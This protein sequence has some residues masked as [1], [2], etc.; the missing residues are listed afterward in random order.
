MEGRGDEG[1]RPTQ[2]GQR[3]MKGRHSRDRGRGG[4]RDPN[5]DSATI[6][7]ILHRDLI[8]LLTDHQ[9]TSAVLHTAAIQ[10]TSAQDR[11]QIH[12]PILC[13]YRIVCFNKV[14]EAS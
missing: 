1:E 4:R 9:E 12:V 8:C 6:P 5:P 11:N 14:I 3:E 10:V 13:T 7:A 2:T